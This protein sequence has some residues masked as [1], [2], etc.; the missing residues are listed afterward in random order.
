MKHAGKFKA[1]RNAVAI[2]GTI[3]GLLAAV[4]SALGGFFVY[5]LYRYVDT[6]QKALPT[7]EEAAN[8]Y[9][10]EHKKSNNP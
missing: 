7:L 8:I 6:V 2:T 10:E 9:L 4:L 5:K 1:I 3:I